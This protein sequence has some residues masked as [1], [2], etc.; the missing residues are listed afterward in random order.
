[1]VIHIIHHWLSNI[2]IHTYIHGL[3]ADR[4]CCHYFQS[5]SLSPRKLL[6][7]MQQP[8]LSWSAATICFFHCRCT[9]YASKVLCPP[10]V[11]APLAMVQQWWGDQ[12]PDPMAP[13]PLSRTVLGPE[14]KQVDQE[15]TPQ[16]GQDTG[17]PTHTK[18]PHSYNQRFKADKHACH[19]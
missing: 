15:R 14:V 16:E 2:Y 5:I 11:T 17:P 7:S 1:M 12:S 19:Y 8:S 4:L 9:A 3:Q 18:S 10:L 6:F 13:T